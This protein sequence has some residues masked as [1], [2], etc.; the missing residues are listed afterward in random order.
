[1]IWFQNEDIYQ[2][3]VDSS[4]DLD[5]QQQHLCKLID[6]T[7]WDAGI[8]LLRDRIV[9]TLI[10]LH[11]FQYRFYFVNRKTF[12]CANKL[13]VITNNCIS[14]LNYFCFDE[15]KKKN[16]IFNERKRWLK[17]TIQIWIHSTTTTKQIVHNMI[18]FYVDSDIYDD[19]VAV[20]D[21]MNTKR[22]CVTMVIV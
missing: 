10:L 14:Q 12:Y 8:L 11:S 4:I 13:Q 20:Q 3:T 22:Y 16:S 6:R 17:C 19:I 18:C 21:D 5:A 7:R 1:M 2:T 15:P 9:K